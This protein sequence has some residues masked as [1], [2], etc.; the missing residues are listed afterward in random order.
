LF[1]YVLARYWTDKVNQRQFFLD[2]A[3]QKK[4]DPLFAKNWYSV[5]LELFRA[6]KRSGSV[7][8][9]YDGNLKKALF[10]LFPNIGLD[11]SQFEVLPCTLI[12]PFSSLGFYLLYQL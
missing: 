6:T 3:K 7:L 4:F 8:A 9:H 12:F 1:N 5:S 2:Y 11:K 10:T